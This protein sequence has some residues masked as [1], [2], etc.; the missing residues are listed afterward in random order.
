MDATLLFVL[1]IFGV[2]IGLSVFVSRFFTRLKVP[3]I[4]LFI[5][6]GLLFG[7]L[8]R[9]TPIG[10][11]TDYDFGNVVSSIALLFIIFYGGFGTRFKEAKP[12]LG[13]AFVLSFLG[14]LLTALILG[15]LLYAILLP[16]PLSFLGNSIGLSECMLL[17]SVIASTDAASVFD[18]LRT[19]KLGL[20]ENTASLLEMES[21]SN[22]PMAYVLTTLLIAIV[23]GAGDAY[24]IAA[25]VSISFFCQIGIGAVLGVGLGIFGIFFLK[26]WGF[27]LGQG[28]A[29]FVLAIAI[30]SYVLPSLPPAPYSGN[31]YLSCYIAGILI[32]NAKIPEKKNTVSFMGSISDICQMVVFFLMGLLATPENLIEPSTLVIALLTFLIITF[33][34]RPISVFSLLFPFRS[35]LGQMGL[36]SAAG[37]RGVASMV[38]AIF[39]LTSLGETTLPFDIFSIVFL[40]MLLSLLLEGSSLPYLAA[41]FKMVDK[42]SD[43]MRTFNDYLEEEE[44]SFL[45]LSIGKKHPW[46]GKALRECT[47]PDGFLFLLVMRGGLS[48]VPNGSTIFEAGDVLIA[49]GPSFEGSDAADVDEEVVGFSLPYDGKRVRDIEFKKGTI[50]ALVKRAGE[51]IV[52]DGNTKLRNG[53]IL[54]KLTLEAPSEGEITEVREDS[55]HSNEDQNNSP[56][57]SSNLNMPTEET[58]NKGTEESS[59]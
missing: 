43:V 22:D 21:G 11:F 42:N 1:L 36:V 24:Q 15:S 3:S 16:F 14:T 46:R 13:K 34:A 40:I 56:N 9:A 5:G 51:V 32:G 30:L 27:R 54:V 47:T 4:V 17:G 38:F 10:N 35:S 18:I 12:V 55:L 19:R 49:S 8:F 2:V 37:L 48:F 31:G 52:P 39:A 45:R 53:D 28:A 44:V 26:K 58:T 41:R 57:D 23:G 50:L 29:I 59:H 20:R 7:L 33:I 25:E 6:L